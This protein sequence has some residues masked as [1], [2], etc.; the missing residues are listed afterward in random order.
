MHFDCGADNLVSQTIERYPRF[1]ALF[2]FGFLDLA[3]HH[4]LS[5]PPRVPFPIFSKSSESRTESARNSRAKRTLFSHSSYLSASAVEYLLVLFAPR[6]F[7][8]GL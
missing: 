4:L 7:G 5:V 6:P 3:A 2:P 8:W 1:R